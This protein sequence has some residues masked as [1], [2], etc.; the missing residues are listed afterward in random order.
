M[1][2]PPQSFC[3]SQF[4]SFSGPT[5][6]TGQSISGA[7]K[8][9]KIWGGLLGAQQ[10]ALCFSPMCQAGLYLTLGLPLGPQAEH[11]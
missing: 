2:P 7:C 3:P 5:R 9:E 6:V 8:R 11:I 4:Q 10:P 1:P